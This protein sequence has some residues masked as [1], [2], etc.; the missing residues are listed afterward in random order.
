MND[1]GANSFWSGSKRCSTLSDHGDVDDIWFGRYCSHH[2]SFSPNKKKLT[3]V[4][5]LV[6]CFKGNGI[7]V[8]A[9]EETNNNEVILLEIFF[10]L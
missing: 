5:D 6:V 9:Q 8:S 2:V 3:K 1:D 10:P 7:S 4:I